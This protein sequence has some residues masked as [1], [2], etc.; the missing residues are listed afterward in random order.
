LI[1]KKFICKG[2]CPYVLAS[3][4]RKNNDLGDKS[5]KKPPKFLIL[6]TIN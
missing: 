3:N 2:F 5:A 4:E 1:N 6:A